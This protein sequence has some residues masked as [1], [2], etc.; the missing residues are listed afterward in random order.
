ALEQQVL[1]EVR[2]ASLGRRLVARAGAD[3]EAER[4]RAH[5]RQRLGHDPHASRKLGLLD[6]LGERHARALRQG[7]PTPARRWTRPA[8]TT[9]AAPALAV[10]AP[11]PAPLAVEALARAPVAAP[12]AAA[13]GRIARAELAQ[14]GGRLALDRR[15]VRQPQAD[16]PAL[17]IHLD[18]GHLE[19]VARLEHVLDRADPLAGLHVRDVEEPVGALGELDERAEGGGLDYLAPEPVADLGLLRHRLD[20]GDAGLDQAAARRVHAHGAVVLDVDLGLE[21]LLEGAD[22]LAALADE[23]A[24]LVRVDLDRLD[25]RGVR[26]ELLAR[27]RYRRP[28][29]LEDEEAP[30]ARLL[31]RVAQDL[32]R[33]ALDLDVHL[34]GGDPLA[35]PGDLEVHVPEVVLDPR[36]VGEDDVV[37]ALLDQS[38]GDAGH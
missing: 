21:L 33:D 9:P 18:H 30:A 13:H 20:P 37:V 27:A 22:R 2:D 32:E 26:R 25:A 3:P 16:A 17:R 36:D 28:H 10:A 23:G 29:L 14:L 34:E 11:A 24:D 31:E 19:L 38:Q 4:D 5:R 35:G 6:A 1:E 7:P 8:S 15:V 12:A